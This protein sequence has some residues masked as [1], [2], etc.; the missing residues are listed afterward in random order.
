[1]GHKG[2]QNTNVPYSHC[3]K[4]LGPTNSDTKI[5]IIQNRYLFKEL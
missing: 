2:K 4:Q 1:M 5:F 3:Y